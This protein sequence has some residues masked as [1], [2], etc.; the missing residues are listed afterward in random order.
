MATKY[1]KKI[2]IFPLLTLFSQYNNLTAGT[3][4]NL[5]FRDDSTRM[6]SINRTS[7]AV[8]CH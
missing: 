3:I 4:C 7:A 2:V 1:P 6:I 5:S 8:I